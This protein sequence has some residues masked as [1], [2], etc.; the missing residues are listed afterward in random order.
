MPVVDKTVSMCCNDYLKKDIAKSQILLEIKL[1]SYMVMC[2]RIELFAWETAD[3]WD[4][5]GNE[6]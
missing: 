3:G 5:W 4:S 1:C 2:L 6:V